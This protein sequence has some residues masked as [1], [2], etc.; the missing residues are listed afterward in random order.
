VMTNKKRLKLEFESGPDLSAK[1]MGVPGRFQAL[2]VI[3]T[4]RTVFADVRRRA[5]TMGGGAHSAISATSLT[6][7]ARTLSCGTQRFARPMRVASSP[8]IRRPV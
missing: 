6:A 4:L 1:A 7:S 2:A 3:R 5:E 8:P